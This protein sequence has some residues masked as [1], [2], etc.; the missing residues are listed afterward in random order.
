VTTSRTR[1]SALLLALAFAAPASAQIP[2]AP[3]LLSALGFTQD[4]IQQ[5]TSGQIVRGAI[6]AA[7]D[8][9][10]VAAMAFEVKNSPAQIVSQLKAGAGAKTDPTTKV[11]GQFGGG[12]SVNDLAKLSLDSSRAKVYTSASPG[13]TLNLSTQEIATF[14]A[15]AGS[16]AATVTNAVKSQLLARL[17]AYQ[18]QGL[19]GIAPYA[20][21]DGSRSCNDE[22]RTMAQASK[23]LQKYVPTAYQYLLSYPNSKPAGT[24]EVFRWAQIDAHGTPALTLTHVA[25]V[26]DGNSYVLL[27]RMFYV[28]ATF[29]CEQALAAF[30]PVQ[31]G[32]A[33]VYANR[34]STDQV[35]GWGGDMKRSIGSRLLES[36]LEDQFQTAQSTLGK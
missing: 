30:V 28:S 13:E 21:E 4:Q 18:Q 25:Y 1:L 8:R 26:P 33:V 34:T 29:N 27:Q 10:L 23:A 5:I 19:A 9:E 36:Q 24:E 14:D 35:E 32:T 7:S 20:R 12:G 3:T 16:D 15:L 31:G 17:K 6:K 2:D 11:S 22:L